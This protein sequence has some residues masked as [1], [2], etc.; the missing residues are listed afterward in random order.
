MEGWGLLVVAAAILLYA[1]LSRWLAT[2]VVSAAMVFVAVGLVTGP[3]GFDWL[4]L[5]ADSAPVR[6]L[7]EATLTF[8]LFSDASRIDLRRLRREYGLPVRLLA[9]GLPLTIALGT[10]VAMPMFPALTGI[11]AL[12]LAIVLAPTDAALGQAVVTDEHVPGRIR[13]SLNVESGLND[14]I[15]VP[16][17]FVA[18]AVAEADA[19]TISGAHA[20]RVVVEEIGYG[21]VGGVL[22][23]VIGV[24]LLGAALRRGLADETWTRVG[25]AATAAACYGL[26]APPGGSGFIAAFVGGAVF[27]GMARRTGVAALANEPG[28]LI[29]ELGALLNAATFVVF[30]AVILGPALGDFGADSVVYAALSLTVIRMVP[31]AIALVGSDAKP[32]TIAFLGWFGPRG[33]ASIVFGVIIVKE[34]H[35]PHTDVLI[36]TVIATVA[37]SVV[38]HGVSAVPAAKRYTRWYTA[39]PGRHEL[40]EAQPASHQRWRRGG[41]APRRGPG[42]RVSGATWR[43]EPPSSPGP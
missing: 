18:L 13:Q 17:L 15:C 20:L 39:H 28:A 12:C 32:P 31:V 5:R 14:G 35:L 6:A 34:A 30:G 24:V 29:E 33:L 22:A 41:I 9:V 11:E 27:G 23:G 3:E 7:A 1:A 42:R 16:L 40:M 21:V 2:T 38:A 19:G 37:L 10:V 8:V 25:V 43:R 26:A 4:H 36:Q